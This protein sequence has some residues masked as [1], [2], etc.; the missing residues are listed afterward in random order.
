MPDAKNEPERSV[1]LY[2][3]VDDPIEEHNLAGANNDRMNAM[4][5]KINAWWP[6]ER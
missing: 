2:N 3:I 1:E 6:A 5:E 4:T